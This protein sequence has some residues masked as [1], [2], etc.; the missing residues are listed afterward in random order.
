MRAWAALAFLCLSS[1]CTLEPLACETYGVFGMSVVVVDSV[2]GSPAPLRKVWATAQS[3]WV[4]GYRDSA[5]V[6][7]IG[8][9]QFFPMAFERAGLYQV[10]AGAEGYAEWKALVPVRM[11]DRCHVQTTVITA[12]LQRR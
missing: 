9:M 10:S 7:S 5:F 2:S 1:S 6:D 11:N 4:S 12:R 8:A 3:P